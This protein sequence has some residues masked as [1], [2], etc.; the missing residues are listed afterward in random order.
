MKGYKGFNSDLTCK[1]FKYEIGKTYKIKEGPIICKRGF[2][3]C[4]RLKDVL[5][6]YPLHK[7]HAFCEIE[8]LGEVVSD[9]FYKK[10]CT[11]KI[12]VLRRLDLDEILDII[13][14]K[15]KEI[16]NKCYNDDRFDE[17]QMY[18][19]NCG[20]EE[21]LDIGTYAKPEFDKSQMH[22]IY[23]GL[24]A[25]LDVSVYAKPEFSGDQMYLIYY[26]LRKS[27]DVSTYAKP[28]LNYYQMRD[29]L[30]KLRYIQNH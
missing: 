5:T 11:N 30:D 15:N 18:L 7:K 24:A 29:I 25:G 2:H 1:G 23:L 28:D 9:E 27:L 16:F 14:M 26:G 6:Y 3:F 21:G 20:I 10:C 22:V 8:A 4:Y 12:K 19:I 17:Y 13:G